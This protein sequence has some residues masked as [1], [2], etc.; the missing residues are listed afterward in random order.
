MWR[1]NQPDAFA[2]TPF[3]ALTTFPE[4]V[5]ASATTSPVPFFHLLARLK[6]TPREG[7]RRFDINHGESIADHMYRMSLLTM[8]APPTLAARLDIPRCTKM[9]L[10]HDMAESIV[11]DITP[12]DNVSKP[13]K[14]RREE[15]TMDYISQTLLGSVHGGIA[16]KELKDVWDEYEKSETLEAKFV[17]DIDK[18]ELLLQMVEYERSLGGEVDLS[19]FAYV[20]RKIVLPEVQEWCAQVLQERDDMWK[21]WAKSPAAHDGQQLGTRPPLEEYYGADA[22]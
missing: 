6:T 2:L 16:G 5:P 21:K 1:L 7:W 22:K 17:H 19:E 11:G 9:A 18:L 10:V 15:T 20:G 14:S 4:P 8:L 12:V 13:E 3:P